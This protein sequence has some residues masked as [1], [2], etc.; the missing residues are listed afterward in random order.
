LQ[1]GVENRGIGDAEVI[2]RA[3]HGNHVITKNIIVSREKGQDNR[4]SSFL[5][6][7][8]DALAVPLEFAP[9]KAERAKDLSNW[10]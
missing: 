5:V 1:L 4:S 3:T 8:L 2:E 7:I 9:G 10:P 6:L